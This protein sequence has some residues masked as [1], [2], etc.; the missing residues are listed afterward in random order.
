MPISKCAVV[1]HYTPDIRF[2]CEPFIENQSAYAK[3]WAYDYFCH[4]DLH[5][6][7]AAIPPQYSK[8]PYIRD[9]LQK[10]YETV[11]WVDADI[12]FTNFTK[13]VVALVREG[14][15]LA[16]MR[17]LN[18][19]HPKY[20]CAGLLVFR[21]G[22]QALAAL[23]HC[24][25]C[26]TD[27]KFSAVV[28][29]Q[30]QKDLNLY[31]QESDFAGV[32]ACTEDEIGSVWQL[33]GNPPL[34]RHWKRGDLHI[35]CS[36]LPWDMRGAVFLSRYH[37][38]IIVDA[39]QIAAHN[40]FISGENGLIP[41]ATEQIFAKDSH[42]VR[43]FIA[44]PCYGGVCAISY[45]ASMLKLTAALTNNGISH[46]ISMS[47]G[48]MVS[49]ARNKIVAEFLK[50]DATHLLMIDSDIGFR[51]GDVLGMLAAN[52]YI[53]G[54]IYP[55]K[56]YR[57]DRM[58][59]VARETDDNGKV[60]DA[61]LDY[62]WSALDDSK[63]SPLSATKQKLHAPE[64][65]RCIEVAEV[66]GAF[67]LFKREMFEM[68]AERYPYLSYAD[69]FENNR[70]VRITTFFDYG[71]FNDRYVSEDYWIARWWKA[72]GGR[73]WAWPWAKLSH[74]GQHVFKGEFDRQVKMSEPQPAPVTP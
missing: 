3:H 13:D 59:D 38:E 45:A 31:L 19:H 69:D 26:V 15:W 30:E 47:N 71:I 29:E 60:M 63:F 22:P 1:T 37:R 48:E 7:F 27:G 74:T 68:F 65:R 50:T 11:V 62:V 66:G 20:I 16:G 5:P 23:D 53:V 64:M 6:T 2:A 33:V 12:A 57:F 28:G 4:E 43:L 52:M 9:L 55:K 14:E 10:G 46:H 40:K 72:M 70:G 34:A 49:R 25:A 42:K 67:V 21:N 32:H 51:A 36:L 44:T 54:G 24:I 56:E 35:H 39:S 18:K 73:V 58:I 17:E 8:L 61:S 41:E